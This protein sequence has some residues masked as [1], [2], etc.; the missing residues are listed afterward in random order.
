MPAQPVR[1][2]RQ[3]AL[4][5]CVLAALLALP[6]GASAKVP[7][8]VHPG[9]YLLRV[10]LPKSNGYVVS[11]TAFDR[12]QI[13]L[14]AQKGAYSVTYRVAG[15]A[16]SRRVE[17]DFGDLGQ[18]DLRLDLEPRG[19]G[20]GR[21][22]KRCRGRPPVELAGRFH[23]TVD[24]P[25]EPKIA[26][27]SAHSGPALVLRTF[28]R[29]CRPLKSPAQEKNPLGLEVFMLAARAHENGRTTSFG[30]VSLGMEGETLLGVVAGD[31]HERVGRVRI[32]RSVFEL[33]FGNELRFSPP[34][35]QPER[36]DVDPSRPFSGSASYLKRKGEPA[37]WSGDLA[38]RL[39][40][41]GLVPLAGPGFDTT[42]C[43]SSAIE[44]L[45][46]CILRV[47]ELS[48][49]TGA[50]LL[51]AYGSGSHSQPLALARLSSLR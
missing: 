39:P 47:R 1:A 23:G 43:R 13:Y 50:A 6:T 29:V 44:D 27:V 49:W 9:G 30:T 33:V 15:R 2:R 10:F 28:R 14:S 22:G 31:V 41:A 4:L 21:R 16:S 7:A 25:G 24:F 38:A 20:D 48:A 8:E 37:D 35:R 3:P 36:A 19:P 51:D 45:D 18:V 42:V 26:G 11:I 32:R 5:L 46:R 34:G 40:E 17:A 12:R